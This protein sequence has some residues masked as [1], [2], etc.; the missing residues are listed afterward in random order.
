[1]K[2]T[3]KQTNKPNQP[4]PKQK[5]DDERRIRNRPET[6]TDHGTSSR[7]S[8]GELVFVELVVCLFVFVFVVGIVQKTSFVLLLI[9]NKKNYRPSTE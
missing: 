6:E 9:N 5:K 7:R 3:N 4:K 2:Q 1:M 8:N